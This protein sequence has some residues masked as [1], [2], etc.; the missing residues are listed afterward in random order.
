GTR[1]GG[2]HDLFVI[3]S[4]NDAPGCA[5][6]QP[7]FLSAARH[8]NLSFRIPTPVFGLGLVEAVPDAAIIA[9]LNS[10]AEL[11]QHLGIS[12]HPNHTNDGTITRFGWKAQNKSMVVFA[13]E[14]SN[15]ELG[16]T[17]EM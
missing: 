10:N 5:I 14:A 7:D 15:V 3:S 4:R 16:R 1:D 9:N 13:G 2:V 17:N 8:N 11:K 12:G 6:Q